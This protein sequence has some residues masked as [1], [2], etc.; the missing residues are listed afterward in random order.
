[1]ANCALCDGQKV[2]E[3]CSAGNRRFLRCNNCSYIFLNPSDRLNLEEEKKRYDLHQNHPDDMEYRS[4]LNQLITVLENYIPSGNGLDYGCGPAPVLSLML[5]EKGFSMNNYDPFYFP[6][7]D[8]FDQKYDLITSTEA[9]EHFYS[10]KK[11]LTKMASL[12]KDGGV[13][14]V[15][16]EF[17]SEEMDFKTWYYKND[18]THVGFFSKE[19]LSF[20]AQELNLKVNFFGKRVAIFFK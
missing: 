3:F 2:N 19:S 12:L 6:S 20:I 7:M 5:K 13:L 17:F 16:T 8:S 9:L 14:G 1:M 4:F 18:P 15:M 11:E 10:P